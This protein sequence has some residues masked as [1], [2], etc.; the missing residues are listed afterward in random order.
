[1]Y[2][3]AK[4]YDDA[5]I[6][7]VSNPA[8]S[9]GWPDVA[10]EDTW[11]RDKQANASVVEPMTACFTQIGAHAGL[12]PTGRQWRQIAGSAPS[13]SPLAGLPGRLGEA[14]TP[15]ES[16][17]NCSLPDPTVRSRVAVA[18]YV[19]EAMATILAPKIISWAL[20]QSQKAHLSSPFTKTK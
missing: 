19:S 11:Q 15:T 1:M 16:K 5:P 2:G 17:A 4:A 12:Y 14:S 10:T 18:Q 6:P 3:Y 8:S 13:A 9:T 20:I 7:T